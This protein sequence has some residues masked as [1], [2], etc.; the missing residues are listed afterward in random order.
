MKKSKRTKKIDKFKMYSFVVT[1]GFDI[2]TKLKPCLSCIGNIIGF[3]LPDGRTVRPIIAL[4]IESR[5]GNNFQYIT[6][7]IDMEDLGFSC[8]DYDTMEFN[9]YSPIN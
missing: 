4:E 9:R 1:G 8:L 7:E 6:H 2:N 5:N 3:T